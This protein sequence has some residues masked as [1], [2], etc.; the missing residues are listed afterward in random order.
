[1]LARPAPAD[2]LMAFCQAPQQFL[3]E[4]ALTGPDARF[5]MNDE[6]FLVLSDPK[7]IHAVLNGDLDDFAKGAMIEIPREFWRDGIITV[8]GEG[9]TE[10]HA[11]LGPPFARRRIRE[12]EPLIGKLVTAQIDRW[13]ALPPGE[14]VDLLPIANRLAFDVV[15]KGLLDIADP[16]IADGL[17]ETLGELDNVESV[18]LNYLVKR[19]TRGAKSGFGSSTYEAAL[20]RIEDL[21]GAAADERLSRTQQADDLLGAVMATEAFQAY[22]PERKRTFLADQISTLLS[23]GYVTT[24]ES[25]FWSLYLLAKH[26]DAQRRARAEV[27]SMTGAAQGET[28]VDAP[29][30]LMA[31]FNEAHR[32]YPPVWFMGRVPHRDVRIGDIDIP[33]GTRVVC[34]PY[35]LGRMPSLWADPD[36]YRPE[37]FLPGATPPVTPRSLIP[38]G[39]GMRACLGRG[40]AQ[41]EMAAI[42]CMT[43]ARFELELASDAPMVLSS[44]LSMHPR[45]PVMFQLKALA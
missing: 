15:A 4:Q 38:Y 19:F 43:L 30:Y 28:P 44:A 8:E 37:R 11:M 35:V 31:A 17:Y 29:P 27:L 32:L 14:L 13:S 45:E 9:W 16:A 2:S 36:E 40:L 22:T 18:R 3:L 39:T 34:S 33:A 20:K 21:S 26:P 5:Q 42:G 6:T 23:A 10:Q 41:M 25:I 12:L 7:A 24:G 1:M